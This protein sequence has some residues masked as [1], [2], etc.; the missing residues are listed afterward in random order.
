[1]EGHFSIADATS[2]ASCVE[3]YDYALVAR[4]ASPYELSLTD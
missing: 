3:H 1:M 2:N 4:R